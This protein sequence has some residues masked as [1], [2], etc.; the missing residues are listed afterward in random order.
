MNY[1]VDIVIAI[2]G[3]SS[4]S[5][6]V[7]SIITKKTKQDL[8]QKG[9]MSALSSLIR[10]DC[11]SAINEGSIDL[12]ELRRI[13]ENNEVYHELG[14]NGYVKKLIAEVNSLPIKDE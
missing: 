11:R 2:L 4:V 10:I 6:I 5:A 14:G 7:A 3:S 13:N 9:L 1:V 8:L 12:V